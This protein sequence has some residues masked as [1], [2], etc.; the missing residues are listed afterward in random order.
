MSE[1]GLKPCPFCGKKQS[2]WSRDCA[3]GNPALDSMTKGAWNTRPIEDA[4]RARIAELEQELNTTDG[5]LKEATET[6][7]AVVA[8]CTYNSNDDAKI[9]IYGI[10]QKAF[11][12]IDQ[13]ITHYNDAISAGKVSVDVKRELTD[14]EITR[15][16]NR[17]ADTKAC[18]GRLVEQVEQLAAE[19]KRLK[20]VLNEWDMAWLTDCIAPQPNGNEAFG[21][22]EGLVLCARMMKPILEETRL[23]LG[24]AEVVR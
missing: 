16:E 12:R 17:F 14:A 13:F 22:D 23:L 3:C 5:L 18:N 1:L 8:C 9:G 19:N 2:E 7:G 11:T 21:L 6:I 20:A 15:L 10:D 4:L 24:K